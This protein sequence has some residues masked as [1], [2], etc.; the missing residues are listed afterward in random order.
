MSK[1]KQILEDIVSMNIADYAN[2]YITLEKISKIIGTGK[3]LALWIKESV[4]LYEED[5][6]LPTVTFYISKRI[7]EIACNAMPEKLKARVLSNLDNKQILGPIYTIL[8]ETRFMH[9][10]SHA[11]FDAEISRILAEENDINRSLIEK[12]V[13]QIK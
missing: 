13:T 8:R 4:D 9:Y 11:D 10:A 6:T 2:K 7:L 1:I 5:S 12:I 3:Q